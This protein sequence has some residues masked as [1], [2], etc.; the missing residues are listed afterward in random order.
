MRKVTRYEH[1]PYGNLLEK[2]LLYTKIGY[3]NPENCIKYSVERKWLFLIIIDFINKIQTDKNDLKL[4]AFWAFQK[5]IC[6]ML[7]LINPY[8]DIE[9][10]TSWEQTSRI[11]ELSI[12]RKSQTRNHKSR[13]RIFQPHERK[14]SKLK[15]F[16]QWGK[17]QIHRLRNLGV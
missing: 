7:G 14:A 16:V 9:S 8:L 5:L 13:K 2:K 3:D 10:Q 12:S 11:G 17:F 6:S 4:K 15:Y 1:F